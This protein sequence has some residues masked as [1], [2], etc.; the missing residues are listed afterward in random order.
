MPKCIAIT[1]SGKRCKNKAITDSFCRLHCPDDDHNNPDDD[2]ASSSHSMDDDDPD[3]NNTPINQHNNADLQVILS[4][5][6][7]LL[8][9][10]HK[11][12]QSVESDLVQNIKKEVTDICNQALSSSLHNIQSIHNINNNKP[13][14][15]KIIKKAKWLFYRDFVKKPG[16]Y[17]KVWLHITNGN[18]TYD[19]KPAWNIVKKCSDMYFASNDLSDEE[20][21]AYFNAALQSL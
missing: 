13:N 3:N 9:D 21:A 4:S 17:D 10:V 14:D 18:A 19:F 15:A 8:I 2:D 7:Q 6:Q 12:K 11:V 1:K 5:F 16:I 20:R